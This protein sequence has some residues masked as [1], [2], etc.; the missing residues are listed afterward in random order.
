[1]HVCVHV[2]VCVCAHVCVQARVCAHACLCE[3]LPPMSSKK[4]CSDVR[5]PKLD[6]E[7]RGDLRIMTYSQSVSVPLHN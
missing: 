7:Y 2:Y 1:M 3:P 5:A 4:D 6:T